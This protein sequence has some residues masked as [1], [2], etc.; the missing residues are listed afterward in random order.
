MHLDVY[1][2]KHKDE[3][4]V[5]FSRSGGV[6]TVVSDMIIEFIE[7]FMVALWSCHIK[8]IILGLKIRSYKIERVVQNMFKVN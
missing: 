3:S 4:V 8:R 5:A 2:V 7:L 1:A 6:F